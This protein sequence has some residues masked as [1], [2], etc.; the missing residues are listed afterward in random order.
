[1]LKA[2]K[3]MFKISD[4][5]K[6]ITG[7]MMLF[8]GMGLNNNLVNH[9]PTIIFDV[10]SHRVISLVLVMAIFVIGGLLLFA[11]ESATLANLSKK[12]KTIGISMVAV[13][14]IFNPIV[15]GHFFIKGLKVESFSFIILSFTEIALLML[16]L[17]FFLRPDIL[18]FKNIASKK[19]EILL[20]IITLLVTDFALSFVIPRAYGVTS[21]YGWDM[22]TP[23]V[24]G[25]TQLTM[26]DKPG[27]FR[28]ITVTYHKNWFKRWGDINT[29]RKKILIIGDSF[30][31]D[32][33]VNNGEEWYAYLEKAYPD[34]EFFVYGSGGYS[35]LQE[36][37]V[38]DDYIDQINPDVVLWQ[39]CDN[40]YSDNYYPYEKTLKENIGLGTRPY[41]VEGKIVYRASA[42][43]STLRKCSAIVDKLMAI[44]DNENYEKMVTKPVL[45]DT[46][47]GALIVTENI[48]SMVKERIGERRMY[49][50]SVSSFTGKE[51]Q[52]CQTVGLDCIKGISEAVNNV[53]TKD[54]PIHT[55]NDGHWNL[56]G[57]RIAGEALV[58]YFQA[59]DIFALIQT[60]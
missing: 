37:M 2:S 40:D 56:K 29:T 38:L 51:E 47:K 16:G 10:N 15:V 23:T 30:T 50:F 36:Y 57:N 22:I 33:F 7:L 42:L 49:M 41:L 58:K 52:L 31:E 26:E 8:A 34:V 48:L 6:K 14:L 45:Q 5:I 43:F 44:Y 4:K 53:A 25:V 27:V 12:K 18:T 20:L 11:T 28:K 35:S 19:K 46:E 59:N 17:L 55:V 60:K 32:H 54:E 39:F 1:M 21:K 24:N 3:P 9:I 13:A